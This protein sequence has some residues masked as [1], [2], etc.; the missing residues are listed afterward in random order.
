M[1]CRYLSLIYLCKCFVHELSRPDTHS[2][3][4]A[5]TRSKKK[6]VSYP[7]VKSCGSAS[8]HLLKRYGGIAKNGLAH[9]ASASWAKAKNCGEATKHQL[10][11]CISSLF[12]ARVPAAERERAPL[13]SNLAEA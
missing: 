1:H 13:L 10:S 2:L 4:I 7:E 5:K 11:N 8:W 12:A 9:C 3:F 6:L